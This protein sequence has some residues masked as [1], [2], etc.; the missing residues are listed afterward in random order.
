MLTT[1]TC[2]GDLTLKF[3]CEKLLERDGERTVPAALLRQPQDR[4]TTGFVLYRA[5]LLLQP[6]QKAQLTA[7]D[8]GG[9]ESQPLLR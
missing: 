5:P 3:G 9:A 8:T 2:L 1:A 6:Q 7:K 4:A